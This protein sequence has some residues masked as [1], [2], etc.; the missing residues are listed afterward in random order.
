MP[1]VASSFYAFGLSVSGFPCLVLHKS[2]G[3]WRFQGMV[4]GDDDGIHCWSGGCKLLE[5]SK[6]S[7][8]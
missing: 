2:G 7:H 1:R 6:S 4:F 5:L 3:L 8:S